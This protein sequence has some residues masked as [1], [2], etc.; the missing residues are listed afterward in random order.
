MIWTNTRWTAETFARHGLAREKFWIHAPACNS[1]DPGPLERK[2][3]SPPH[4]L[5]VGKDWIR[6]GG[7]LL[8][9]AF[10]IL[11][12]KAPDA[13][14]TIIGC[15]PPIREQGVQVLGF[16][17][18]KKPCDARQIDEAFRSATVFCMPSHWESVGL[19]Y[20]EAAIYGLPVVMLQGQG[21]SE[22]FPKRMAFHLDSSHAGSLSEVLIHLHEDYGLSRRMGDAGRRHILENY[23]WPVVARRLVGRLACAANDKGGIRM[24]QEDDRSAMD[25]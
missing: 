3:G 4:V 14:L 17:D 19:V 24:N 9:D 11:R 10:A 23:T 16:L 15:I 6:K 1:A 7:P 22:V 21:R 8:L 13:R 12:K 18:K 20:M 25:C 5:F 2:T